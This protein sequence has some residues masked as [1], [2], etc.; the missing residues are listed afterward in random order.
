MRDPHLRPPPR[1]ARGA[2]ARRRARDTLSRA[3]ARA[4]DRERRPR[5]PRPAAPSSRRRRR[6]STGCRRRRSPSPA[7]TTSRTPCPRGSRARG[8]PSRR[9]SGR[10]IPVLRTAN[11]VVCGLNSARPWRHQGGRLD[12]DAPRVA[13]PSVLAGAPAGALRDRRLP[14]PPRRGAVARLAEVP[15]QAPRR[16]AAGARRGRRGARPRR[17]Y[18]SEHGRRTARVRGARRRRSRVRSSSR[19]RPASAGRARTGSA[20]PTASTSSAGRRRRSRSRPGSGGTARFEPTVEF[21]AYTHAFRGCNRL[22][23]S[24][25]DATRRWPNSEGNALFDRRGERLRLCAAVSG[26][27]APV[28][29]RWPAS[30]RATPRR[31]VIAFGSERG[32]PVRIHVLGLQPGSSASSSHAAPA[33]TSSPPGRPTA[34]RLAI[35]TSDATRS[36]LRHRGRRRERLRPHAD[37]ERRGLGRGA[38]LVAGREVDRLRR[39][40]ATATSTST[41]SIPTARASGS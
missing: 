12:A 8:S 40:T 39:A 32:G 23:Q 17:P 10:P 2:R 24:A 35:A 9:S 1:H 15:A 41:S 36:G 27:C 6:C 26:R 16:G 14:P 34:D 28:R 3:R 25:H 7:T 13:R 5:E 33:W 4:R 21:S 22:M 20:R 11:A 31:A 30:P 38:G 37:H 18:P 29:A 19:P